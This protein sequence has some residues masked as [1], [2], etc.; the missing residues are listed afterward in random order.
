[1]TRKRLVLFIFAVAAAWNLSSVAGLKEYVAKPDDSYAYEFHSQTQVGED[2]IEMVRMTS[3][4]WQN[5]P[6]QHWM[7]MIVPKEVKHPE[8][9]MLL[10]MGYANTD[11]P[12]SVMN[13]DEA[14][15]VQM[16]A[17]LTGTVIG[18]LMQVPNQPLFDGLSEDGLISYTYEQYYKDGDDEWPL[19]LP[20]AKSAVRAMDTMQ[21]VAK[22][23][24]QQDI[25]RFVVAGASKRGWTTWLTAVAD[26][27]VAAI[28]PMV[29]DVLN[30]GPQMEH[31]KKTYG[32]YSQ[33]INDYTE[34]G[35]QMLMGTPR[36]QELLHVVDPYSY[37]DQLTMPKLVL[38]GTNDEYWC[39]DSANLYFPDLPG[40]KHLRYEPN[41]GHGLGFGIVPAIVSFYNSVLTG[42]NVPPYGWKHTEDGA[43]EVTWDCA[44][45]RAVL[46]QAQSANRD[47]RQATWIQTPL[48][49]DGRA[50]A[51]VSAP[52]SG[53]TA[54][55]VEIVFPGIAGGLPYGLCT[56]M[57]VTPDTFPE[58]EAPAASASVA[59]E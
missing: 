35:I 24:H 37:R 11:Q 29:I 21:A 30:M 12:P 45:A 15:G 49:G 10:V 7:A 59:T 20:M 56:Q 33:M 52:A 13:S 50:V 22:E 40:E 8:T 38:L 57:T 58:H 54:Y 26:P 47:F 19:L 17:D 18:V 48:D 14:R 46:W 31:Q 55:Y 3:Q 4:T 2:T 28:C 25:V 1:M 39:V 6:W 5:I 16:V 51:R 41:A 27:R 36:G 32:A 23:R 53:W 34:R 43:L 44:G 9:A 42:E